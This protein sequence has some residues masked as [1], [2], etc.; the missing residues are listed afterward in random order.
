MEYDYII[1][2]S[3][4]AGLTCAYY[5]G[6]FGKKVLLIDKNDYIGG[7]HQVERG[8][9][10][11]YSEKSNYLFSDSF[12]NFKKL[13]LD[14]N[15]SFDKLFNPIEFNLID[16]HK[17]SYSEIFIIVLDFINFIFNSNHGRDYNFNE[18]LIKNKFSEKSIQYINTIYTGINNKSIDE[19][20]LNEILQIINNQNAYKLYQPK[21]PVDT[22][23]FNIWHDAIIKTNNVNIKLN[24]IVKK[25]NTTNN[26]I[27]SIEMDEQINCKNIILATDSLEST[28]T[29]YYHWNTKIDIENKRLMEDSDWKIMYFI[30]SDNMYFNDTR[31][32]FVVKVVITDI[33]AKSSK[34][35]KTALEANKTEITDEC[36]RQLQEIFINLPKPT[37]TV[38]LINNHNSTS[39][40]VSFDNLYKIDTKHNGVFSFESTIID[41]LNLINKLES[42]NIPIYELDN[43]VN[44]LKFLL[45]ISFIL[46]I[47][48]FL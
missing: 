17:F 40:Q 31:S 30:L 48:N 37:D 8:T 34:I 32:V 39:E 27:D 5:L 29:V 7:Y 23:L 15:T 22:G 13:L 28:I 2:G 44:I 26:N 47:F 20:S 12:I 11:L 42:K 9:L 24:T 25:F 10:N 43:I 19:V 36:F 21:V 16:I 41:S 46:Q 38:V 35:N 6:K 18:Y 1:I 45:L 14:F 4:I 33:C 3:N